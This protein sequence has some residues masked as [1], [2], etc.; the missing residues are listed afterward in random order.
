MSFPR[1]RCH[2]RAGGNPEKYLS[3]LYSK[4]LYKF[5]YFKYF[6]WILAC[7]GMTSGIFLEPC[8]NASLTTV[9]S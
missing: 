8:N 7:A 2:S 5:V 4:F 6:F 9:S 3:E 1:F